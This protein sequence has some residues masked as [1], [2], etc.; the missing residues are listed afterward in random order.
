MARVGSFSPSTFIVGAPLQVV[1]PSDNAFPEFDPEIEALKGLS[2]KDRIDL[3]DQIDELA[4]TLIT[5]RD[6]KE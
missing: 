3:Q 2:D 5:G 4:G 1:H 6:Y